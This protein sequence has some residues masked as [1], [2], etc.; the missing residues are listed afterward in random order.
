MKK[1]NEFTT[2][3][4]LCRN[5]TIFCRQELASLF[6]VQEKSKRLGIENETFRVALSL[7]MTG[8]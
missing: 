4:V 5:V 8:T 2:H 1:T 3:A 7:Q 6:Q